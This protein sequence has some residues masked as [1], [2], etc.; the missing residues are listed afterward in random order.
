MSTRRDQLRPVTSTVQPPIS[1]SSATSATRR[2]LEPCTSRCSI[3]VT[4]PMVPHNGPDII[5]GTQTESS[6]SVSVTSRRR[7]SQS[8]GK[9]GPMFAHHLGNEL[10][11]LSSRLGD[12]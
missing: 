1:C 8:E 10:G 2:V 4:D 5:A 9:T 3:Q 12:R 7:S 11:L 6:T